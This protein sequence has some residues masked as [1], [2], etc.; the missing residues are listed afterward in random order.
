MKE[1]QNQHSGQQPMTARMIAFKALGA[2]RRDGTWPQEAL[3]TL[4]RKASLSP[5]DAALATQIVK[6][7]IQN[8]ALID[9][10]IGRFSSTKVSQI[11]PIIHDILRLSVYQVI[12]LSFIPYNAAVNEGVGLVKK[13][14]D[15]GAAGYANAVLREIASAA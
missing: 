1:T 14:T 5:R 9:Y 10:Y 8:A 11:H 3:N 2:F 13:F 15:I 12:F 4:L 6:G 7:T